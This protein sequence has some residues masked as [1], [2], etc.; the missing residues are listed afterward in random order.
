MILIIKKQ[1]PEVFYLKKC[2]LKFR[3]IHR[4]TPATESLFNKV[5]CLTSAR[6]P[7]LQNNS[8]RLLLTT[9]EKDLNTHFNK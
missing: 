7:S 6:A 4:K 3:K 2:S 1:P 9:A 8:G 5:T